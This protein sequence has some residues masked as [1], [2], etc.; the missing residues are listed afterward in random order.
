MRCWTRAE[1]EQTPRP[2]EFR[3][4][5]ALRDL[6]HVEVDDATGGRV[7]VERVR[8]RRRV[9]TDDVEGE[10]AVRDP[11]VLER[12]EVDERGRGAGALGQRLS[13]RAN[14]LAVRVTDG[15]GV[16]GP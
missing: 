12:G 11:R 1:P 4:R 7:T 5:S 14:D 2:R 9:V 8:V 3:S 10:R 13:G 15:H 6:G 16:R